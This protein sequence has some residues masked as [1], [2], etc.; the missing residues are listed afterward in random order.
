MRGKING[1]TKFMKKLDGVIP[2]EGYLKVDT[3]HFYVSRIVIPNQVEECIRRVEEEE[4]LYNLWHAFNFESSPQGNSYW[5]PIANG[6]RCINEE[7]I[8]YLHWL[9]ENVHEFVCTF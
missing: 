8:A 2:E 4:N 5:I 9:R 3:S 1:F 7:G 6:E